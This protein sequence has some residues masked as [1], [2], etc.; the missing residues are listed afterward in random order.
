[1][2]EPRLIGITQRV[3]DEMCAV[4]ADQHE[5]IG[6]V[7]DQRRQTRTV[8]RHIGDGKALFLGQPDSLVTVDA[9]IAAKAEPMRD[10]RQCEHAR[11]RTGEEHP[12]HFCAAS[13]S[14][15]AATGV[16]SYPAPLAFSCSVCGASPALAR[17][18]DHNSVERVP[19]RQ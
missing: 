12:V 6:L 1:M 16:R 10:A 9:C 5:I 14:I 4:A 7:A 11:E 18:S 8:E 15:S 2:V 13:M 17:A 3:R 19:E